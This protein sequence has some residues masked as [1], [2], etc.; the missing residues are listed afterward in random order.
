MSPSRPFIL[1]P[2]ATSLLMAAIL[3]VGIVAFT[4]LPVSALPEVDY[5][6]IQVVTF[7]PGASPDVMATT[8]TAPLE[9]QF[10]EMQGLSQMTSTS[11][12]GVSVIVLQFSLSLGLDVAEE[13]VQS[14]I[15]GGQT[16][17]PSDLPVPPVYNK[18]NPADAPVLTL[19]ITSDE[20][21]LSEVEDMVD[22]RLA[23][24]LSQLNG[25][26]LV[27]ISGGQ[28]PA[29]RIQVNPVELSSYGL[30][31]EDV[32]TA[33]TQASV[34][35]A[36]GNFDGPRQ[37]Y[38]IDA[39][40]QITE[41]AQYKD[42]VVAY[43]NGAPVFVKDVANVI[44]GVENTKEAAWMNS[45]PAVILN[46]Q[47]QPGA[48]TI[49]VV[50]SIQKVLPQLEANLPA[51]I[52]VTTLTDM[53]TS[54]QASVHDVEFELILT[55]GLVVLVIFLFLRSLR[56]TVIPFVAV[57]LSIIGAFA[58]MYLLGYSLD[59]LSLMALTISTGF[60]VDDAIVMIENISRF[61]EEGMSPL[62]A[63]LTGADQIGFTI[64]SLTVSL[65]AVLIPLLFMGDVVGRLFREF[66]VTLAVTIVISAVVSLTLTPMMCSRILRHNPQEQQSRFYRASERVFKSLIDFYGRTLRV[67]LRF[68]T[69]TL[70][71]AVATLVLTIILYIV[72]PKGFF[73]VQDT[74]VIQGI[75]QASQSISYAA[76][77][78]K[79]KEMAQIIL[80]DQAVESL[81]SFIG[82][83]GINTTLN[84]G[85]ISI[86]LKPLDQRVPSHI[87]ASDVIRRLQTK[88]TQVQGIHLYMQPVQDITVDDRVSRT[89]YQ[90]T[91]ED[92]DTDELNEWT[93][94]FTTQLKKLPELEDVATDQQTGAK[95]VQLAIDRVTASRLGIAPTTIDNTLYDA[96]GQRE[97]S[98]LYTQ[99]NQY[100]V[101]LETAPDWQQNPTKLGDLYIQSSA[102]SNATGA[103]AATS[104]S[105][106]ASAAA[107]SNA[108]T[109]SVNYTPSSQVITSP[110]S[111]LAGTTSGAGGSSANGG[112]AAGTTPNTTTS[113]VGANAIPLNAFTQVHDTTE[114]LSINHQGQFP[115]VTV[116]F[117]L[118]PNASLGTAIS[119]IEKVV[120]NTHF[121]ASL[122]SDFQGTAASFHN[123]LSNEALLILAALVT[124]YI[125][126][127]VLYESFIHPITILSTLPSA[128]VGA[129][130]A[131]MVFREDLSVVGIIGII[132]L[133]GIV[134]KNGIMIVDFALE[135]E[136]K[137]GKDSTEA[138]YEASL[139]RFRP[140]MMTTMAALLG[141]IP[142][143]AGRGL[144]SELRRP[145]GIAMVGGL[146]L[147]QVL[148]LYTT[149]VIYIFF[150]KLALRV[151]GRRPSAPRSLTD[152]EP[153]AENA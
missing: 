129:L 35:S 87:S 57:P 34:N 100:H 147:S 126:L 18:T 37:D 150:D 76:M 70:L 111:V 123:S 145:L 106:S 9:R 13:E 20:L 83:D 24:R 133:I 105:S 73:P 45:T 94:K 138:I 51:A 142:L 62:E 81:S 69:V 85:R 64:V 148:T 109:T 2:V 114:A 74:G 127:G 75:S 90:Y 21:P 130:L 120:K 97:I 27:S 41:A 10:G 140:I 36:K 110:A 119:D 30:N 116:S 72:I 134:K 8:V 136:R 112:T 121:P 92:P 7:Y 32:R 43:S 31:M 44:N 141:G 128:G 115:S 143:A 59:N 98:T 132:L 93:N 137:H 144:G 56:A 28:K 84:S 131:L 95:A 4:Q 40:D 5:P 104:F 65:V 11:A 54:I 82:A 149:P 88:L 71:V 135:A 60:V 68:Q 26:G 67:V 50:N 16:F 66:A 53:T 118:A 55:I 1:R 113:S 107:G 15:N 23:P 124:V 117:N 91:L 58:V 79:Q 6:T 46:I 49:T 47:R 39:N 77:A 101:V 19:A 146:L 17:L 33:L 99:L 153:A 103:G 61:L 63:A 78:E 139:L 152:G 125:V 42:V 151:T 22:T 52:K 89:Q 25:V 80:K 29:V 102:S 108:L 86:N 96:Y 3:L 48:N 38:Q 12:G 14:A 122:Q